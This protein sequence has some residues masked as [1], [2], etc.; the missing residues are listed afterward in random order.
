MSAGT[1]FSYSTHAWTL[2]SAVV[3]AVAGDP[4]AVVM[5]KFFHVMGLKYTYL[6]EPEPLIYNRARYVTN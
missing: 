6:D 3:E 5:K 2:V 4:F 1:S